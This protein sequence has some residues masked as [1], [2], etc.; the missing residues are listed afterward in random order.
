[1]MEKQ[2]LPVFGI[3]PLLGG[4]MLLLTLLGIIVSRASF[5][6]SGRVENTLFTVLLVIVGTALVLLGVCVWLPAAVGKNCIDNFIKT[7][8][9]CTTG[10]Y[11]FVR[12][13]C[14][15][16][17]MLVC[18]GALL[19]NHNLWLLVLVPVYWAAMTIVLKAT[20]EKWLRDLY[21]EAYKS[22][23]KTVN[24]CFPWFKRDWITAPEQYRGV[25]K[26]RIKRA[27]KNYENNKS[28]FAGLEKSV[29]HGQGTQALKKLTYGTHSFEWCG[30][31]LIAAANCLH[32][33]GRKMLLPELT[34]EF[35]LN[36]MQFIFPS[37]YFGTAPRKICRFFEHHHVPY[38][39]FEQPQ[40][41]EEYLKDK[42]KVC[43]ILSFWNKEKHKCRCF[44]LQF[45]TD[46]LH[47]VAFEKKY[48]KVYVYNRTNREE[49]ARRYNTVSDVFADRKFITAY[50]MDE[51]AHSL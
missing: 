22:Y 6:A 38:H 35:E 21:G 4:G 31:E 36:R 46:G 29:L 37:G 3:G 41:L 39:S 1:M 42:D 45:F 15:S 51:P 10:V 50:V 47:T 17:I 14:Y 23:C 40:Q 19:I 11:A 18:D 5:L 32:L 27:M 34:Y 13:P 26:Y 33:T 30:C 49:T 28:A 8:T 2:H 9:L 24:R 48:G 7:N 44:P 16:G 20:E 43:G 12:N 25:Q